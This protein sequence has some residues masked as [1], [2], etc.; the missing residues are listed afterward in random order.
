MNRKLFLIA[1]LIAAAIAI[2]SDG[3]STRYSAPFRAIQQPKRITAAEASKHV[4]E[5]AQVCGLVADGRYLDK[6]TGQPTLINFEKKYPNQVFT[7]VIWGTSR[8]EFGTPERELV[9]K[10]VCVT[11]LIK[12]Y[13]DKPQIEAMVKSQV[14]VE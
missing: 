3:A 6:S 5:R 4:G 10:K 1:L 12:N 14:S 7:L 13:R 9:G 11:G 8:K 2:G